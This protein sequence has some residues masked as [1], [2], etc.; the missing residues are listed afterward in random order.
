VHD[1]VSAHYLE[2]GPVMPGQ[3]CVRQEETFDRSAGEV[4]AARHFVRAV[5]GE[6][7]AA[8]DAEL[9][10]SEL[11]TNCVQH[12]ADAAKITVA[13]TVSGT[14]VHVKVTG[15]GIAGLPHWRDADA[16]T[17]AEGGR[18][19]WLLNGIAARWGFVR[20]RAPATTSCWFELPGV[21]A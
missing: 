5:L 15:D 7:P 17:Y 2:A 1:P 16:G 19:F 18:G 20:E 3:A 12:T 14:V 21:A 8:H 13:V 9:L 6:H 10:C 4:P 11:V